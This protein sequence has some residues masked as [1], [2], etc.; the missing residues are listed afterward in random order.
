MLPLTKSNA[1]RSI[2]KSRGLAQSSFGSPHLRPRAIHQATPGLGK[3]S[4]LVSKGNGLLA[5]GLIATLLG[6]YLIYNR[7]GHR[8]T[9]SSAAGAVKTAQVS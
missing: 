8:K 5:G 2:L 1:F 3:I 9:G 7:E 4:G 6:G